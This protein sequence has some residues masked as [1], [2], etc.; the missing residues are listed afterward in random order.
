MH[1]PVSLDWANAPNLI[2]YVDFYD[3]HVVLLN[4]DTGE[5]TR[6]AATVTSYSGASFSPD[7][8]RFVYLSPSSWPNMATYTLSSGAT[9]TLPTGGHW[10][11]WRRN[12]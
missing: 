1:I 11:A 4:A 8:S 2:S 10:P 12:P 3:S 9:T 7:G 6:L 5:L